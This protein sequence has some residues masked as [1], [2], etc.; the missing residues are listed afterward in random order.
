VRDQ[1]GAVHH[2]DSRDEQIVR[3]YQRT[4]SAIRARMRPYAAAHGSSK[5]NDR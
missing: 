1:S 5:A 4:N 2:R 3:P